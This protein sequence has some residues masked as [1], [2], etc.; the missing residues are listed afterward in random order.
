MRDA[1]PD[2]PAHRTTFACTLCGRT[3]VTS[4]TGLFHN[5]TTGSPRR[6]CSPACRQAAYRRRQAGAPEHTPLQH[7]GGRARNLNQQDQPD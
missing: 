4:I 6:F 1:Y 7:H 2:Q 5:P 3:T